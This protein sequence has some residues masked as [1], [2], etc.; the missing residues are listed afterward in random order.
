MLLLYLNDH[1]YPL[2]ALAE[3]L[4]QWLM[5]GPVT[6]Q[7]LAMNIVSRFSNQAVKLKITDKSSNFYVLQSFCIGSLLQDH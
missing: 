7:M 2:L 4:K 3:V 5:Q 6:L 1:R